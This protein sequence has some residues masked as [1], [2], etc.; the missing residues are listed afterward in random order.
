MSISMFDQAA[1]H[2]CSVFDSFIPILS[3]KCLVFL[4]QKN[5]ASLKES[6]TPWKVVPK[7][8]QMKRRATV[9][10]LLI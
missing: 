7:Q 4:L 6:P 10:T 2:F 1:P 8:C 3:S 9:I 5:H